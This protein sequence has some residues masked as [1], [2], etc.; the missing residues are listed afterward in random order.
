MMPEHAGH[1]DPL[2][3]A[4]LN[5]CANKDSDIAVELVTSSFDGW[6]HIAHLSVGEVTI[7]PA[8][9][10]CIALW[11][12]SQ[13]GLNLLE[14]QRACLMVTVPEG[15]FEIRLTLKASK[16]MPDVA[17]LRAYRLRVETVRDKSAPYAQIVNGLRFRLNDPDEAHAR[18]KRVRHNL[19]AV[20]R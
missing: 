10:I 15:V 12:N 5:W 8:G 9:D 17:D 6:P 2:P 16:D 1:T 13:G 11:R 4:L 18:W 20:F 3:L 19:L 7:D 14:Q